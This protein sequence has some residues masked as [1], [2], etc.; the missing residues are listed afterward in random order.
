MVLMFIRGSYQCILKRNWQGY[1]VR[2]KEV[3]C[4]VSFFFTRAESELRRS[5]KFEGAPVL[6]RL[7]LVSTCGLGGTKMK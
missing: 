3:S 4:S 1:E 7:W 6:C 5:V 2:A